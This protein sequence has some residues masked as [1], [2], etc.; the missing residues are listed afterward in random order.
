MQI[1]SVDAFAT[2]DGSM[3]IGNF[4]ASVPNT[5]TYASKHVLELTGLAA[6]DASVNVNPIPII[7]DNAVHV[8]SFV[9][10]TN[11]DQAYT[12]ADTTLLGRVSVLTNS[13]FAAYQLADP[14]LLGDLNSSLSLSSADSTILGRQSVGVTQATIPSLPS[15]ITPPAPGGPDPR[16]FIPRDLTA[17]DVDAATPGVQI[18]I[19]IS[20]TV[21]EASGIT[22]SGFDAAIAFDNSKTQHCS[23]GCRATRHVGN[24]SE[25]AGSSFHGLLQCD[26]RLAANTDVHDR[27]HRELAAQYY[28]NTWYHPRDGGSWGNGIYSHKFVGNLRSWWHHHRDSGQRRQL[29]GIGSSANECLDRQRRWLLTI[30]PDVIP[31]VSL[32]VNNST[33]VESTAT[34]TFTA[35]LTAAAAAPVT[36]DLNFAGTATLTSDYTRSGTQIV[37]PAGSLTGSINRNIGSGYAR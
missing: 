31:A 23:D 3:I 13:G 14:F 28:R 6:A 33:I 24:R 34:A 12:S 17:S 4:A 15:G 25:L 8:A 18:D 30:T 26:S 32:S 2:T 1:A 11:S 29:A 27:W 22:I 35:T 5:A 19:P 37:I 21:T 36:V 10:D 20:V 9:G 7:A 16:M